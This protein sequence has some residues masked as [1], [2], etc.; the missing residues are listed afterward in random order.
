MK[1][2]PHT[3]AAFLPLGQEPLR[4]DVSCTIFI[5]DPKDH[6]G[7]ELL[8]HLG[9]AAVSVKGPAGSAVFYPLTTVHQVVPVSSGERTVMISFI[10]SQIPDQLRREL[11]YS[12]GEV[13]AL[14]GLK[15]EWQNRTQMEFVIA[16]LL[17]MWVAPLTQLLRHNNRHF[18]KKK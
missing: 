14:E 6:Q 18:G 15:M 10:E 8:I 1:Y 2:G 7:G 12:S 3:D 16:N 17:G 4:S 9:T 5:S 11:L 13:R